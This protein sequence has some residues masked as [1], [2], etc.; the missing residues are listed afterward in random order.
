MVT[1]SAALILF[2]IRSAAKL[3]Q[4][5]RLAYLDHTRRRDLILP[6]PNFFSSTNVIDA[7]DY[8]TSEDFGLRFVKGYE[9]KGRKYPPD[10]RLKDLLDQ[11]QSGTQDTQLEAELVDL[12]TKY[13]NIAC[14]EDGG[15]SWQAD[16]GGKADP[17]QIYALLSIQQWQ[18]GT[19]P[20][21]STL[22]RISG[23]II[24]IGIDY[25]LNSPELFDKNSKK[26]KVVAGFLSGLDT[27]ID[28]KEG[29]LPEIPGRLFVAMLETA[30]DNSAL[31][32]CDPKIQEFV[33]ITT[34]SLSKDIAGWLGRI[35]ADPDLAVD[36]KSEARLCAK[37]WAEL[38]FRGTLS[39]GGRLVLSDPARFMGV[40]DLAGQALIAS[41]GT[42][43]LDFILADKSDLRNVISAEGLETILQAALKTTGEHPEILAWTG[44]VGVKKLLAGLATEL[45]GT[46][47]LLT[48][49]IFPEIARMVLENTGKNI[50]LFW[51]DL[52][53]H[54]ETHL[55]VTAARTTLEI[56]S[57]PAVAGEQWQPG[58]GREDILSLTQCV[59]DELV[60]NPGWLVNEAG[61]LS[62][63]LEDVLSA[64]LEVLRE[65]ADRRLSPALGADILRAALKAM[66]LRKD[67]IMVI[68]GRPAILAIVDAVVAS[69][70]DDERDAAVAWQLAGNRTLKGIIDVSLRQMAKHGLDKASIEKLSSVMNE[71]ISLIEAGNLFD[72]DE[73][74]AALSNK[75]SA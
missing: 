39:S 65:R 20:T 54:P 33:N 4:Q 29:D 16:G 23:T 28:F 22:H 57:R 1:D 44:N 67:F 46:E 12:H 8:F 69:I 62:G 64:T 26:G 50:D 3:S 15:L 11:R 72:L 45:A 56:L 59:L 61:Q 40:K 63:T 66:V 51:P 38:V 27:T 10:L 32:S 55:L 48:L 14:A 6:L 13:R 21:P 68:D 34:R 60:S 52:K 24:E 53:N 25:A 71:Q 30:A 7:V 47:N 74:A 37:D 5:I 42:S 35:D 2:A 41:V 43:M 9:W 70:F 49:G 36:E 18:R 58:F 31:L 75:L 17:E 73:F 19:D